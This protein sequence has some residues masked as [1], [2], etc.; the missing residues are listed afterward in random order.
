MKRCIKHHLCIA[1][2]LCCGLA[3]FTLSAPLQA[4][5]PQ[6]QRNGPI[7][8][9]GQASELPVVKRVTNTSITVGDKY[10]ETDEFTQ[11]TVDGE[12]GDLGDIKPGMQAS[13]TGGVLKYGQTRDDT[14]Y[15]ATRIIARKD[16][17]LAKKAAEANKKAAERARK[18]NSN[19]HKR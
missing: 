9:K 12:K 10:F 19:H 13:V 7:T 14:V 2:T 1:T 18:S 4:R 8:K 6:N 5:Q 15:K 16:N 17:E 11:V 3:L